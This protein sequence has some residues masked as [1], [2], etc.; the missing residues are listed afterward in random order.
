MVRMVRWCV[1]VPRRCELLVACCG[2]SETVETRTVMEV[3]ASSRN[4]HETTTECTAIT[5]GGA[6]N[7]QW[8]AVVGDVPRARPCRNARREY[9]CRVT[10]LDTDVGT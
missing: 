9:E 5:V 4:D 10:L 8:S 3:P 7:V 2:K 6:T 1:V